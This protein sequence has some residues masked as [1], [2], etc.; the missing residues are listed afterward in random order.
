MG[1][2]SMTSE[3]LNARLSEIRSAVDGCNTVDEINELRDEAEKIKAELETRKALESAKKEARKSVIFGAGTEKQKLGADN[4]GDNDPAAKRA[5]TLSES[6]RATYDST[7]VRAMLVS[8]G[9]IA[10]PT[11]VSG[12]NDGIGSSNNALDLFTNV[13]DCKGMGSNRVAYEDEEIEAAGPQTAGEGTDAPEKEAKYKYLEIRPETLS[14]YSE[15]SKQTKRQSPLAYESKVSAN[16]RKA[17]RKAVLK[18][19]IKAIQTSEL[20][21]EIEMPKLDVNTIKNLVLSYAGDETVDGN[22]VVFLNKHDLKAL[23]DIRGTNEKKAIFDVIPDTNNTNTGI[24]KDGALSV[25]YCLCADVPAL[26][27]TE[28]GETAKRTILYGKPGCL[29]I[30]LFSD[31][32]VN[33]SEDAA[34][35]K[36]M[37]SIV[38]D[39]DVGC[40]VT[41]KNG[42]I[43]ATI[44][45]TA[46]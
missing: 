42:F 21:E 27:K 39:V 14:C 12:I 37:I 44:P 46:G 45:A 7:E 28:A 9:D 10:T 19:A 16:A 30:D 40:A 36:L 4:N 17:L 35:R 25:R 31:Y 20:V 13:V 34:F 18:K 29:E 38:G 5:A 26:S 2:E 3:Q 43:A 33:T 24:I 1:I 8:S 22:G 23:G 6:N 32:E 41:F 15:I 11:S